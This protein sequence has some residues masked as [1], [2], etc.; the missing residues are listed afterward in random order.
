MS[1]KEMMQGWSYGPS[2]FTT[3]FKTVDERAPDN[4]PNKIAAIEYNKTVNES[5]QSIT[6]VLAQ[7]VDN[8]IIDDLVEST[9][10]NKKTIHCNWF[11]KK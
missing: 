6:K 4:H 10:T 3:L 5:F 1:D 11:N 8:K 2:S 9:Y 7:E